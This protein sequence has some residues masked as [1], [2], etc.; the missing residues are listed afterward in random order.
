[1][2]WV[3]ENLNPNIFSQSTPGSIELSKKIYFAQKIPQD[4]IWK[5]KIKCNRMQFGVH[6]DIGTFI[7]GL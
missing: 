2:I 7:R 5:E 4:Y 6:F 3:L 1:M